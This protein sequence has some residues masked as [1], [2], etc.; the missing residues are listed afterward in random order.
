[1]TTDSQIRGL[2]TRIN[3]L[4]QKIDAKRSAVSEASTTKKKYEQRLSEVQDVKTKLSSS[5]D[6][7][8]DVISS[9]QKVAK[10]I[11]ADAMSGLSKT[12]SL[13]S[14]LSDDL[15][16]DTES[17]SYGSKMH[18]SLQKEIDRCQQEIDSAQATISSGNNIVTNYRS[19]RANLVR[20]AKLLA[21]RDDATIIVNESIWY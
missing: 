15:E 7:N 6:G 4:E 21:A 13:V 14:A 11:L 20:Q 17:D 3:S 18:S 1:M 9:R 19:Q 10:L 16:Y 2:L 8:V 5:F 12:T